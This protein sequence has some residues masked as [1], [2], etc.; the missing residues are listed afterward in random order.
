MPLSLLYR[1]KPG[2][3]VIMVQ[4]R[5]ATAA[6]S[7]TLKC[8]TRNNDSASS[9]ASPRA[10]YSRAHCRVEHLVFFQQFTGEAARVFT[11]RFDRRDIRGA[12]RDVQAS[13][14]ANRD[15]SS[16][17]CRRRLSQSKSR[18]SR[19]SDIAHKQQWIL[20]LTSILI[21]GEKVS[22]I[23]VADFTCARSWR[24]RF[25]RQTVF[26]F[27]SIAG[28]APAADHHDGVDHESAAIAV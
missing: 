26:A 25:R 7:A 17:G 21:R 2:F 15:Q 19:P 27:S 13:G 23:M 3:S 5:L 10:G 11:Q 12:A 1:K 18:N 28:T 20:T 4:Q 22:E 24:R 16:L 14:S 9:V 6:L 8:V